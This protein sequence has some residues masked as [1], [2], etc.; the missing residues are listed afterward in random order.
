MLQKVL[1]AWAFGCQGLFIDSFGSI[2]T[3][4][5]GYAPYPAISPVVEP[6]FVRRGHEA[7]EDGIDAMGI[8]ALR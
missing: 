8:L 7:T 5:D 2:P 4:I 3:H 1:V 6:I